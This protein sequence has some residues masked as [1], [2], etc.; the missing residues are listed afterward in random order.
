M[1]LN[2]PKLFQALVI[3]SGVTAVALTGCS[4]TSSY[5]MPGMDMFGWGK[6]KPAD[7]SLASTDRTNL[8]APPSNATRPQPVPSYTQP[9]GTRPTPTQ[10]ASSQT[11]P[12]GFVGQPGN[13]GHPSTGH[14]ASTSTSQGFYSPEYTPQ[15]QH[16]G[17]AT[18]PS[19]G[20]FQPNPH[21]QAGFPSAG[22]TWNSNP[23]SASAPPTSGYSSSTAASP[24]APPGNFDQLGSRPSTAP[25]EH[26]TGQQAAQAYP[27]SGYSCPIS[28]GCSSSPYAGHTAVAPPATAQTWQQGV[29]DGTYRPG[30][31]SR[32]TPYGTSDSIRMAEAPGIQPASFSGDQ[33]QG[34]PSGEM[35]NFPAGSTQPTT[36]PA[37]ANYGYPSIYR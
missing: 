23:P 15:T 5:R 2:L 13:L 3:A 36:S 29:A 11:L 9:P 17:M 6:K 16:G 21:A 8:P 35:G 1:R 25:P 7:T 30:S 34:S 14:P 22:G 32:V 20:A 33:R 10:T 24:Y 12:G 19:G 27:N 26:F 28:G 4:G 18:A 37:G 31:T